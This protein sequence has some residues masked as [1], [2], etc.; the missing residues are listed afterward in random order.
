MRM[1]DQRGETT[2]TIIVI[3]VIGIL[4]GFISFQ[5]FLVEKEKHKPD[6]N[7]EIEIHIEPQPPYKEEPDDP[8]KTQQQK[9]QYPFYSAIE[10]EWRNWSDYPDTRSDPRRQWECVRG[11]SNREGDSYRRY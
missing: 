7:I 6:I 1:N 9:A 4:F 10:S 2:V 3:V 5:D 8:D 11:H